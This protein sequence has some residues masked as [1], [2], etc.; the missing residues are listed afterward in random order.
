MKKLTVEKNR[1]FPI[2]LDFP[3][4]A[5]IQLRTQL[6]GNYKLDTEDF[7]HKISAFKGDLQYLQEVEIINNEKL[8]TWSLL[9]NKT[10]FQNKE[11]QEYNEFMDKV[12][13]AFSKVVVI[14][15]K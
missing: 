11:I 15:K 6:P 10:I 4:L 7:Q 2:E 9:I 8:I 12:T 3:F 1:D 14:R 13:D 5:T